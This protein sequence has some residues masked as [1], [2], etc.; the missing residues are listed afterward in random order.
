M[1]KRK[2][3]NKRYVYIFGLILIGLLIL[4]AK[5]FLSPPA[6]E[7]SELSIRVYRTGTDTVESMSLSDYLIGVVAAEMPASFHPEA[8]SAQ[9]VAARTYAAR[10]LCAL[11][12]GGCS[13]YPGADVCDSTHCQ[14]YRDPGQRAD[15]WGA[16]APA[17]EA[18]ITEAV[19]GTVGQVLVYQGQL[20]EALYHAAS[21]GVTE[22]AAAAFGNDLPYLISVSSA[23]EN[24]PK[25]DDRETTVALVDFLKALKEEDPTFTLGDENL[26]A[27]TELLSLT[28]GGRV[29][30]I[31]IG[32]SSFS[33]RQLRELFQLPSTAFSLSFRDG[34]AVFTTRGYGHGV[35][36]SQYGAQA[37]AEEGK[38]AAE[39][40][41]HYYPG[42]E[43][44]TM[45]LA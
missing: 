40:L 39:I 43:L 36:M 33:G 24:C 42:T 8:L 2:R 18:K 35:G 21:G 1:W 13:R 31:R 7:G 32:S 19:T 9:A 20:I 28:T 25:Y 14:A 29:G 17:Y 22:A 27:Q 15:S 45:I 44:K 37:M 4:A 16:K 10:K 12:G 30:T 34:Q 41:R 26:T 11:G 3:K 23:G 38:T 5:L 6:E